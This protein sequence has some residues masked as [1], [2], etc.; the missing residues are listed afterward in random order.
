MEYWSAVWSPYQSW[1]ID[2]LDKIQ[3]RK[4]DCLGWLVSDWK[5]WN[6]SF[7][8]S[9]F[10][11]V[12]ELLWS[13]APQCEK[14]M[15]RSAFP[16]QA[17]QWP[18]WYI[19]CTSLLNNIDFPVHRGTRSKALFASGFQSRSYSY[20][21]GMPRLLRASGEAS[22]NIDF[23]DPSPSSFKRKMPSGTYKIWSV[24]EFFPAFLS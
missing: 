4:E 5:Y 8:M 13:A 21:H 20:H 7:R 23:F 15:L 2:M 18:H 17:G 12:G 14:E 9:L 3:R 22:I 16:V 6:V 19:D 24:L 11:G 1:H 10:W